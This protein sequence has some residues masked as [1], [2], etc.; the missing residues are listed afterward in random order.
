MNEPGIFEE[1]FRE[2]L[3][4]PKL[5]LLRFIEGKATTKS[6]VG[7]PFI[8]KST[9]AHDC[10]E[11]IENNSGEF[12]ST[13][14]TMHAF[15]TSTDFCRGLHDEICSEVVRNDVPVDV[16]FSEDESEQKIIFK[17]RNLLEKIR[18]SHGKRCIIF[19]DHFDAVTE[20]DGNEYIIRVIRQLVDRAREHGAKFIF[21]SR[22]EL[23]DIEYDVLTSSI[24]GI[25]GKPIYIKPLNSPGEILKGLSNDV[26]DI[27]GGHPY[28]LELAMDTVDSLDKAAIESVYDKTYE[29]VT[30]GY[31]AEE[32]DVELLGMRMKDHLF[33]IGVLIE[34][35]DGAAFFSKGFEEHFKTKIK[36][37]PQ[38]EILRWLE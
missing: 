1:I 38:R 13:Y 16:R 24:F 17:I 34:T 22:R 31:I 30:V 11:H 5:E 32:E 4:A 2:V 6:I 15:K 7:I 12:F 3:D 27:A 14:L 21:L 35:E 26:R 18:R 23:A 19:L 8:G 20:I 33:R 10:R 25:T 37:L 36:Q 9:L 29:A 28:L